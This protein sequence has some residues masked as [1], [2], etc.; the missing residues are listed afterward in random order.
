MSNSLKASSNRTDLVNKRNSQVIIR[1][2]FG[3]EIAL[4]AKLV[5]RGVD[6]GDYPN[7]PSGVE[8]VQNA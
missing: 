1:D 4:G 5:L 3:K 8:F 2:R 7:L 6:E